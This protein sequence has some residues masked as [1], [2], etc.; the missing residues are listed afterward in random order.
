MTESAYSSTL[1]GQIL[2][3]KYEVLE[4]LGAGAMGAIYRARHILM[5]REVAFKILHSHL[6][7][8][9]DFLKRFRNEAQ[10]TSKLRHPHA[11]TIFDYGVIK[12]L[13]YIVM[14]YV[15][16]ST[17]KDLILDEG[18]LSFGELFPILKQVLSALREAHRIGILHRDLKPDNFI[19]TKQED[20][21]YFVRV[22]DFGVAKLIS[23]NQTQT[24]H[25]QLEMFF[26]TPRYASPEQASG[27]ELDVRTDIY[28][29][30]VIMFEALTGEVPFEASSMK[31]LLLKHLNQPPPALRQINPNIS[32][33]LEAVVLKCL[34]KDREER[35]ENVAALEQ[36]LYEIAEPRYSRQ[37]YERTASNTSILTLISLLLLMVIGTLIYLFAFAKNSA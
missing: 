4:K 29:L 13:P 25:Q 20:G 36:A 28:A 35:F 33:S 22:L 9:E 23:Q 24:Q 11:V 7:E 10:I 15:P 17:L 16:G 1:L 34:Q 8:N 27:K 26:G 12:N 31:E 37:A 3:G 32:E 21:T 6:V 14:E 18:A 2:E 30:G 5:E 19:L